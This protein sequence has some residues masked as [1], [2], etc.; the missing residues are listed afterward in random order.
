MR[1]PLYIARRYLFA[2]KK[3]RAVNVISALSAC[4]V[5]LATV[6]LVCT[7]SVFNG[8]RSMVAGFF[9][10]F[11][12]ELK[13]T[14]ARGKTFN[15]ADSCLL[16]VRALP[17]VAVWSETLEENALVRYKGRQ[18]VAVVKG[19]DDEF[20]RLAAIDS[21]LFGAGQY[22]LQDSVASYAVPGVDLLSQLGCG[23]AFVDPLQVFAPR[24]GTRIN[25]ANPSAGLRKGYLH[26]TGLTFVVNQEKY[27]AH[28]LLAPIG[29]ARRLFGQPRDVS[30]VELRLAPDADAAKTKRRIIRLLGPR[31]VVQDR[32]EQQADVFRIM[33]SEKLISY[34][35]L[36]FILI[37]ACF[38]LVGSLSMLMLE[39]RDDVQTLRNLGADTRLVRSIFLC[40]GGLIVFFGGLGG[41]A[42]GLLL[43]RL[44]QEYGFITLGQAGQFVTD[45][46]PVSV[47]AG[48][49]VAVFL[50][51]LCVGG[52]AVW[53]AVRYLGRRLL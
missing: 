53:Y 33:E 5:T 7:L 26:S 12:P 6:A 14:A 3:H 15:P 32:Y 48:D 28:Y 25:V 19:V 49:V 39:K 20:R 29:F 30:A 11:D 23:L 35:L 34:L 43:C 1:L 17:E 16:S 44:Q 13:I 18:T 21:L 38:N 4:G 42:L 47:Q 8:F 22:I 27:D 9:T 46:F 50:T 52:L 45:A 2:P 31:F 36:T 41:I 37:L 24:P 10:A 51:V 40:E